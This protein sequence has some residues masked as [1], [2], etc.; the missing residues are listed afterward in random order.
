MAEESQ[1]A[2]LTPLG[3]EALKTL[4]AISARE[5]GLKARLAAIKRAARQKSSTRTR[6]T[7]K[8]ELGPVRRGLEQMTCRTHK[9]HGR[10][11]G[12]LYVLECDACGASYHAKYL[13]F[14]G[15]CSPKCQ[16]RDHRKR[17]AKP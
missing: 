8:C 11:N 16:R 14:P 3:R 12:L 9:H 15:F 4:R 13:R 2:M 7:A 1:S 6:V 10:G 5:E 17:T